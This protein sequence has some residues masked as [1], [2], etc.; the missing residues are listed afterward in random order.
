MKTDPLPVT[1]VVPDFVRRGV[2]AIQRTRRTGNG[3]H[4]EQV[5]ARLEARLL[6]ARQTLAQRG[7]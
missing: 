4:A 2:E 6:A 3:I 7:L 1:P 5:L